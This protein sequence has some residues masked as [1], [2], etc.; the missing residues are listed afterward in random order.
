MITR[1]EKC[2]GF[3]FLTVVLFARLFLIS[4]AVFSYHLRTKACYEGMV[5]RST[6]V[7]PKISSHMLPLLSWDLWFS[8]LGLLLVLLDTEQNEVFCRMP[9]GEDSNQVCKPQLSVKKFTD[10][11]SRFLHWS[12]TLLVLLF[13][14]SP[15]GPAM[16][17]S[18]EI[19]N[20]PGWQLLASLG[21]AAPRPTSIVSYS[22]SD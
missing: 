6:L 19:G 22:C 8:T 14:T 12:S 5:G 13:R 11:D 16:E 15:R 18:Q 3:A 9:V 10:D 21:A 20:Q 2:I 1:K 7:E 17:D 4:F